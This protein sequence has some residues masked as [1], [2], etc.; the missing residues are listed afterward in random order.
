VKLAI[1][2]KCIKN[3]SPTPLLDKE[4]GEG[5]RWNLIWKYIKIENI[6]D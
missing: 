1:N 2:R 3:L 6:Y 5:V 4:R